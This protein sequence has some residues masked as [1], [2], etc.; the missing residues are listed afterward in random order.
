[1]GKNVV[2]ASSFI[3]KDA[4]VEKVLAFEKNVKEKFPFW[5]ESHLHFFHK[6]LNNNFGYV[7][8][9]ATI[10]FLN[11]GHSIT[12]GKNVKNVDELK[13]EIQST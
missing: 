9:P 3:E 1:M 6:N 4:T 8:M 13:K 7:E 11:G 5:G 2:I 10:V 12:K